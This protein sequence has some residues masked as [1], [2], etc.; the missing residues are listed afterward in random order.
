MSLPTATTT[1]TTTAAA[2]ITNK[3]TATIVLLKWKSNFDDEHLDGANSKAQVS[4]PLLLLPLFYEI[5]Q[6][7]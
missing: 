4:F 6:C 1:Y 7:K 5:N 3:S 2:A